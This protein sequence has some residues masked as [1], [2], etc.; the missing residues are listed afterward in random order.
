MFLFSDLSDE[1][2]VE[3]AKALYEIIYGASICYSTGDIVRLEGYMDELN[4]R[5][6][7]MYTSAN[8]RKD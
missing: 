3:E 5:G 1:K 6:Y 8:W 2:L 7:T 4:R